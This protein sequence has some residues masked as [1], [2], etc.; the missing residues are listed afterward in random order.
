MFFDQSLQFAL[1]FPLVE[2]YARS[3]L[4]YCR[5]RIVMLECDGDTKPQAPQRCCDLAQFNSK[6]SNFHL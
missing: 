2:R 4:D 1:Y 3:T 5:Q 6:T